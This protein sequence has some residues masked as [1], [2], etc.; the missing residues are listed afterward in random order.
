MSRSS[1]DFIAEIK[2]EFPRFRIVEKRDSRLS[3]AIDIAL[4]IL[5]LGA[6]R[7]FMT[8][9]HTV[10]WDTLYVPEQWSSTPDLS[11]LI[12]L[13]HERIHLRQRKRYGDL[14]MTFLYLIPFFPLGLAYGRARIEWEAY[15]ETLRATAEYVGLHAARSPALRDHILRQFLSGAYGWMWPFPK[16]LTRWYDEA[17]AQIESEAT[18]GTLLRTNGDS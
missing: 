5:T 11:R 16:M 3:R 9:Y 14:L 10:L 15:T 4:R 17:L 6:Q 18:E 2:R 1:L 7:E 13:R 12:T 8:R